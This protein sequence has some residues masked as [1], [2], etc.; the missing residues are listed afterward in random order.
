[1]HA[2]SASIY[3]GMAA[4]VLLGAIYL[5]IWFSSR[6]RISLLYFSISAFSVGAY[7]AVELQMMHSETAEDYLVFLNGGHVVA[8]ASYVSF[9]LF[10]RHYLNSTRTWI[11]WTGVT[12]RSTALLINFL[13][14][15]NINFTSVAGITKM[16]FLGETLS[17]ID[18]TRNPLMIIGHIGTAWILIYCIDAAFTLWRRGGRADAVWVGGSAVLFMGGRLL[19]TVLVMWGLVNIP[20]TASPFFMGIVLVMGYRLSLTAVRSESLFEQLQQE[21]ELAYNTQSVLD[22]ATA[23]ANVGVWVRIADGGEMWVSPTWRRIFQFDDDQAVTYDEFLARVHPDDRADLQET[24]REAAAFS[25]GYSTEY[26]IVHPGGEVRWISSRGRMET[27]NGGP[28]K[29]FGASAD[30]TERKLA[31]MAAYELGG[32]LIGAQEKERARLARELHDDLSQRLALLSI[33]L[34]LLNQ[35]S[36]KGIDARISKLGDDV[37]LISQDVH[38]MSHELHPASLERLGLEIALGGFSREFSQ[39]HGI[40]VSI[41]CENIPDDIPKP[42]ALCIYRI[43]QEALQNVAKH[44]GAPSCDVALCISAGELRLEVSDKGRGFDAAATGLGGGSIGLIGMRERAMAINGT[45]EIAS[46]LGRGTVISVAVPV[47]NSSE[48]PQHRR[49]I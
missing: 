40:D 3:L 30:I 1:M 7:A 25:H 36:E 19:D 4:C 48:F 24:F 34:D 45:L 41:H 2:L 37:R 47:A 6:S 26:R 29:F 12:L 27:L 44:S 46:A 13:S 35:A 18:G 8:W 20:L 10:I 23:A 38:R 39:A 16:R 15:V 22:V 17:V 9:L 33:E 49:V 32:R 43:V 14:P 28:A 11:F 21:R 42:I 5:R 31:E